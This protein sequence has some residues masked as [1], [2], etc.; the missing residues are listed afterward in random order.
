MIDYARI[1]Q[2]LENFNTEFRKITKECDK[3]CQHC[4]FGVLLQ[5]SEWG[6]IHDVLCDIQDLCEL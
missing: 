1:A 4:A 6:C 5:D 3:E 2:M